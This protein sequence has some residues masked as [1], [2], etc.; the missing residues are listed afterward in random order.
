MNTIKMPAK[1]PGE[2][3][4]DWPERV[5]QH[6]QSI[7]GKRPYND[8]ISESKKKDIE[9]Q[10]LF[11]IEHGHFG[12]VTFGEFADICEKCYRVPDAHDIPTPGPVHGAWV[13]ISKDSPCRASE[14]ATAAVRW[15]YFPDRLKDAVLRPD[16]LTLPEY[17][18]AGERGK[19]SRSAQGDGR[20][21]Q[22]IY[23]ISGRLN[24]TFWYEGAKHTIPMKTGDLL[25]F[26]THIPHQSENTSSSAPAQLLII[27]V[28]HPQQDNG[29]TAKPRRRKSKGDKKAP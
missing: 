7:R 8:L 22:L 29:R 12:S 19:T 23:V 28:V 9:E 3:E 4:P 11:D 18:R 21:E 20:G 5:G 10:Q 17:R 15:R 13:H 26:R 27:R 14:E 1:L 24:V 16:F 2:P 25:H 6:L